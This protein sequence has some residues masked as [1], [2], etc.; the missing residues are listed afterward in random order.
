MK[1][2]SVL[3]LVLALTMIGTVSA[4]ESATES[5]KSGPKHGA[6]LGPFR[7]TKC[8][9]ASDDGVDVGKNICYRCKNGPRPQVMVFT[10]STGPEVAALVKKL[11]SAVAKD[12][13]SDMKLCVFVNL[14][15]ESKEDLSDAAKEFAA[16][17]KATNIPFVVPNEF[18]NGPDDY[19]INAKAEVTIVMANKSKVVKSV[20]VSKAKELDVDA[21][22]TQVGE[23]V[24]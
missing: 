9:G 17:T 12:Q 22:V 19:G 16:T 1:R 20:A 10:R 5:L 18:E 24:N 8:A 4:K 7:V 13:D 6:D 21:I 2:V 3:S 14:L 15:G 23:L 11:D